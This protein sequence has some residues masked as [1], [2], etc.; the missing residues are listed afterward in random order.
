M[1]IREGPY[2][3]APDELL[4]D[5][6]IPGTSRISKIILLGN[7]TVFCREWI[8]I[9]QRRFLRHRPWCIFF[10]EKNRKQETEATIPTAQITRFKRRKSRENDCIAKKNMVK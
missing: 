5:N 8:M 4:P 3:T 7:T 9:H 10:S 1:Y 2:V 6:P